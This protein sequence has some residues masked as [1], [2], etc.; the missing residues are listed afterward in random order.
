MLPGSATASPR[1][2]LIGAAGTGGGLDRRWRGG[3]QCGGTAGDVTLVACLPVWDVFE[4]LGRPVAGDLTPVPGRPFPVA[5]MTP[6]P[7]A[8][9]LHRVRG[10]A[11]LGGPE[12]PV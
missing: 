8:S 6:S 3:P 2:P 1:P 10:R 4:L 11:G 12:E 5:G 9:R 7:G